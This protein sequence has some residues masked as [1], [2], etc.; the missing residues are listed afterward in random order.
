MDQRFF[1][2]DEMRAIVLEAESHWRVLFAVL[3]GTGL[4]AKLSKNRMQFPPNVALRK[5]RASSGME[6]AANRSGAHVLAKHFDESRFEMHYPVPALCLYR[7]FVPDATP[8][9]QPA[10]LEFEVV[11]M[12]TEDFSGA[13]ERRTPCVS[14]WPR[15][16]SSRERRA[17]R[18][19]ERV[20]WAFQPSNDI[21]VHALPRW[22][23][24]QVASRVGLFGSNIGPNGPNF[25]LHCGLSLRKRQIDGRKRVTRA[26]VSQPIRHD[27]INYDPGAI[28]FANLE[29]KPC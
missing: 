12:E 16:Y 17:G 8:Y 10:V 26:A 7:Y 19:G 15:F 23:S 25:D 2:E 24:S 11:H 13:Q 9:F 3:A 1:A 4:E 22:L 14:A 6:H 20:G 18:S 28:A 27:G 21:A 5:W 29:S